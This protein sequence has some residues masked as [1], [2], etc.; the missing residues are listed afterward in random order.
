[1][2]QGYFFRQTQ[3]LSTQTS[4]TEFVFNTYQTVDQ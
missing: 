2:V 3:L 4:K 1:M